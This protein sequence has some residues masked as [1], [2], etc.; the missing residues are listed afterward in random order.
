MRLVLTQESWEGRRNHYIFFIGSVFRHLLL[1]CIRC[2]PK[3]EA[4]YFRD[5]RFHWGNRYLC[6]KTYFN[7]PIDHNSSCIKARDFGISITLKP[8][9]KI[10]FEVGF[11]IF[12]PNFFPEIRSFLQDLILEWGPWQ[13]RHHS[14]PDNSYQRLDNECA[15]GAHCEL[16]SASQ[17]HA[18]N[19]V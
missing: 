4:S 1:K 12:V 11:L 7:F 15:G 5:I 3:T 9:I 18:S 2:I 19:P 17:T 14:Q 16:H 8:A 6:L 10:H 13:R